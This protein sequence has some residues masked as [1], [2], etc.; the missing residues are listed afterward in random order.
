MTFWFHVIILCSTNR[1]TIGT[2][3][4]EPPIYSLSSAGE[5]SAGDIDKAKFPKKPGEDKTQEVLVGEALSVGS[6]RSMPAIHA[7]LPSVVPASA[8]A[9]NTRS[10]PGLSVVHATHKG[11]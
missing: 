9:L 7:G 5:G 1:K 3:N 6:R 11:S 2:S 10:S 4:Q 8:H